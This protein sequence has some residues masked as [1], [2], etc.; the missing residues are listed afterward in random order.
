MRCR[1]AAAALL[2]YAA[3]HLQPQ[4]KPSINL[5]PPLGYSPQA[6]GLKAY[7]SNPKLKATLLVPDG[8]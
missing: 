6:A 3:A 7:L 1:C 4:K 8:E 5:L 2:R